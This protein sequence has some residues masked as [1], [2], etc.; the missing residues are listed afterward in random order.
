MELS[1]ITIWTSYWHGLLKSIRGKTQRIVLVELFLMA[2]L[3]PGEKHDSEVVATVSS[4]AVNVLWNF[5]VSVSVQPC[6]GNKRQILNWCKW[7]PLTPPKS[8]EG[9]PFTL[10]EDLLLIVPEIL[11]LT[12][13]A[14][15]GSAKAEQVMCVVIRLFILMQAVVLWDFLWAD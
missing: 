10:P 5:W 11:W 3:P 4:P 15:S 8:M 2:Y 13:T 12:A 14:A 6:A 7:S 9:W 1:N